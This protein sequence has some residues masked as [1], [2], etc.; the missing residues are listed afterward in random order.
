MNMNNKFFLVFLILSFFVVSPAFAQLDVSAS[1]PSNPNEQVFTPAIS[2]VDY[3]IAAL[4][5]DVRNVISGSFGTLIGLLI[6]MAGLYSYLMTRSGYGFFF[7][8]AGVAL[9]GLPGIFDWYYRGVVQAFGSSG[10][11]IK[12]P[13]KV[14]TLENWCATVYAAS[15][16]VASSSALMGN[17][18]FDI[19][20]LRGEGVRSIDESIDLQTSDGGYCFEPIRVDGTPMSGGVSLARKYCLK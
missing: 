12:D 6:S 10:E 2:D 9:T 1:V 14:T 13:D 4:Y 15:P 16:K 19:R 20:A 17:K 7:F 8:I 18:S 11:L 3:F 5:C